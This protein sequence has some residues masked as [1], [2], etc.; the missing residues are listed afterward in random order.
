M[1][2]AHHMK[3]SDM[4]GNVHDVVCVR[5][6]ENLP[7]YVPQLSGQSANVTF[8]SSHPK[9]STPFVISERVVVNIM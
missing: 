5:G 2:Q 3:G 4:P 9:V 1:P 7:E 8:S 6:R